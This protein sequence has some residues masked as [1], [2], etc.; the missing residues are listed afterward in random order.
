M[1]STKALRAT[2][3]AATLLLC[4]LSGQPLRA[5]AQHEDHP[6]HT[7]L[8]AVPD[9]GFA[10]VLQAALEHA[11]R[12]LEAP[13]RRE[14]AD[15]WR[16]AGN[17]WLAG[18]SALVY[19]LYNDQ[20]LD[21]RGQREY[22]WGLQLQLRRFDEF[23]AA[24][25][26]GEQ[27]AQ[28]LGTWQDSLRWQLA[29]EVRQRLA[30]IE[31]AELGLHLEEEATRVAQEVLDVAQRLFNAGSLAQLDVLQA[32]GLLLEQRRQLLAA[33]A[34]LV[35][36]EREYATLTGLTQRPAAMHRETLS[37]YGEIPDTHPW[38][39]FLDGEV[40]LADGNVRQTEIANKG[41]P[42]LTIGTRRERGDRFIPYTD[43]V[44]ISLQIPIGGKAYVS[45][46]TSSARMQQVDA[47]VQ[48]HAARRELQRLL[49]EAEHALY[50]TRESLPLAQQQAEL[51][52]RRSSMAR[53]A[54]AAGEL[55]LLQVLPAVQEA[56]R[57]QRQ[58]QLLQLQ[59]QRQITEY[60]QFVGVLP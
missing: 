18:R 2:F 34:L 26:Q 58:W 25:Q 39:R 21:A 19:N 32:E 54:F 10:E 12:A 27:Y 1:E 53:S 57:A 36:A 43:A 4:L 30:D 3:T 33:E 20:P 38:L 13:V 45:S 22:E 56:A 42:Q 40:T 7:L 50:V 47:E 41:S 28:Q 51:A 9:L 23:R 59:E 14:Q 55:T 46:R 37:V 6:D 49:H 8:E 31:A 52:Q 35:D 16:A 5:Q 29:G 15:A 24:R 17:S 48:L 60:N 11:P 44:A